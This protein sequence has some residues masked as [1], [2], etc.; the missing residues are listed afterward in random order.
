MFRVHSLIALCGTL[1]LVG[2]STTTENFAAKVNSE[3]V[4]NHSQASTTTETGVASFYS[5]KFNGRRTANGEIFHNKKLTAAHRT[6]PFG[7]YVKVTALWNGRS[8][9]V[10]I[11]DRGPFIKGRVIDLSKAAAAK[12]HL[13]GK[14]V[15]KVDIEVVPA[16]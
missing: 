3:T 16:P 10:K 6:L 2:C 5:D 4:V 7:T 8:V 12:L 15:G 1:L 11:N 13:I 14:G 9:V